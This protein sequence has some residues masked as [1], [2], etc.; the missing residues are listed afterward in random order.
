MFPKAL[1][2]LTKMCHCPR[3]LLWG[4]FM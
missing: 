4:N 3:E 1:Q 2:M